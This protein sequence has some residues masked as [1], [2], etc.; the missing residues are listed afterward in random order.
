MYLWRERSWKMCLWV[1]STHHIPVARSSSGLCCLTCCMIWSN[2][3]SVLFFPWTGRH[4][5]TSPD[6]SNLWPSS[7]PSLLLLRAPWRMSENNLVSE[8]SPALSDKMVRMDSSECL[9]SFLSF[10]LRRWEWSS[11][12]S[13]IIFVSFRVG[14]D[15]E[16]PRFLLPGFMFTY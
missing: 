9:G 5:A 15:L 14:W 4:Q 3:L 8:N 7:D 12:S 10:K 1:L 16:H 2:C 11:Y 6:S 13:Q